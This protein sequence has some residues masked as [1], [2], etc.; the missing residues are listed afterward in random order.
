MKSG[1]EAD[2]FVALVRGGGAV[3]AAHELCCE[4]C[5]LSVCLKATR[6]GR[7]EYRQWCATRH[8]QS[9]S[10]L[11]CRGLNADRNLN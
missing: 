1:F 8:G 11:S 7:L 3:A 5:R 4:A 9:G 2:N 6:D 10:R